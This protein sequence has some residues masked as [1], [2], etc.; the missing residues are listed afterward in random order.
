M[1]FNKLLA[2]GICM[3][4][5]VGVAA[6]ALAQQHTTTTTTTTTTNQQVMMGQD[7]SYRGTVN[8]D[9]IESNNSGYMDRINSELVERP[10]P[11][12]GQ[13]RS[14]I[15]AMYGPAQTALAPNQN[16]EIYTN[17]ID[18]V[19]GKMFR[20][21]LTQ[22]SLRI[23]EVTYNTGASKTA[24]DTATDVKLR[25]IPRVGDHKNM[26]SKL[27]GE[28][29]G[30]NVDMKNQRSIYGIPK[31]RYVF[32]ND[33]LNS[34]FE[35]VNLYFNADGF[36][37]GQEFVESRKQGDYAISSAGRLIE[38]ESEWGSPDRKVGW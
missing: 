25:V 3:A 33:V 18:L 17:E 21:N 2:A 4:V 20:R 19:D 16:F 38:V 13:T 8:V 24:N 12:V 32:Y 36:V 15:E 7:P 14:A 22:E 23:Y 29:I 34:P 11:Q 6:P 26:V 9:V 27:L 30:H 35:A 37:V 28:P 31:H 10:A 1:T 5:T